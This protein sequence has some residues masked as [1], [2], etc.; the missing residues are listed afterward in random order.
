MMSVL[1][2]RRRLDCQKWMALLLLVAGVSAT[3]M[4]M[5]Q[6][7]PPPTRKVEGEASADLEDFPQQLVG[8]GA[9]LLACLLSGL[10]GVY[11]EMILKDSQLSLWIRNVQLAAYSI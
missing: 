4:S 2:L 11:F 1:L 8:L 10:A 5:M 7:Q 6:T 3:Q 9:V